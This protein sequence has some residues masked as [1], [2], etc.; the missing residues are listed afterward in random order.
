MRED[1]EAEYF[2]RDWFAQ[3]SEE[4]QEKIDRA[5]F[6]SID[7]PGIYPV[8]PNVAHVLG[9]LKQEIPTVFETP[10]VAPAKAAPEKPRRTGFFDPASSVNETQEAVSSTVRAKNAAPAA[11]DGPAPPP[12]EEN[13]AIDALVG[14]GYTWLLVR[15]AGEREG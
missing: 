2:R 4:D 12:S 14:M 6:F 9:A 13:E 7:D 5:A 1:L 8:F 15:L 11:F 10:P 3:R